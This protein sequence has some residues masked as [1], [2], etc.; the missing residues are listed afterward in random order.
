MG[1]ADWLRIYFVQFYLTLVK[2]I[3]AIEKSNDFIEN[4]AC[5]FTSFRFK[6]KPLVLDINKTTLDYHIKC[7]PER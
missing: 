1:D 5:L 7:R 4:S 6:K 3:E 2:I